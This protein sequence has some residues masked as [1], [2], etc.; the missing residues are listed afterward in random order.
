MAYCPIGAQGVSGTVVCE[1][2]WSAG[3]LG[4]ES[5]GKGLCTCLW[6]WWT[7]PSGRAGMRRGRELRRT[8]HGPIGDLEVFD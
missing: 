2:G 7:P 5:H 6:A 1:A 3:M 8:Q 4:L